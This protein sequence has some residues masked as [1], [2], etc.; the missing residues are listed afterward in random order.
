MIYLCIVCIVILRL[1]TSVYFL[2]NV[3]R[4]IVGRSESQRSEKWTASKWST[5]YL[6]IYLVKSV[7]VAFLAQSLNHCCRYLLIESKISWPFGSQK[8]YTEVEM[9][10]VTTL[11]FGQ[12]ALHQVVLKWNEFISRL[13][14]LRISHV[15][16]KGT[17]QLPGTYTHGSRGRLLIPNHQR[18]I[19]SFFLS[20]PK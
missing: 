11:Y 17:F 13:T 6:T 10:A 15:R 14:N 18:P 5:T 12:T 19:I 9:L 20:L 2:S 16:I 3:F 8:K 1:F 7:R 4:L